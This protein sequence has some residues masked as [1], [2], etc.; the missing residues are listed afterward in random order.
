MS[1]SHNIEFWK[2]RGLGR[3]VAAVDVAGRIS[4]FTPALS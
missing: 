4:H 2:I 3:F 1:K